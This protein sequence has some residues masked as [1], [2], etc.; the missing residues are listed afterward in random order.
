MSMGST[1][2]GQSSTSTTTL[3]VD[4]V[5]EDVGENAK[6]GMSKLASNLAI[7]S[8]PATKPVADSETKQGERRYV[9]DS[10]SVEGETN[11]EALQRM[12]RQVKAL[13]KSLKR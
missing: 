3:V 9:D 13:M 5:D 1:P 11:K 4:L 7:A 6:T 12:R 2:A 8:D 10:E